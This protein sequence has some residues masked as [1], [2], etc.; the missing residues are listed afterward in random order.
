MA[1]S[2]EPQR[3]IVP[4]A[5]DALD[6][7]WRWN[8]AIPAFGHSS[9]DFERRVDHDRLRGYRLARAR[10]ALQNSPCGA[11]LLFDVN[12]IRYV[13]G[14]KIGEWERDKLCRFAL[15]AGDGD[16]IVW[17][18]GSAAVHHR[19]YCDWLKP[20]D[21]RAGMLGM[22]G[23]VPP[24]VGLMK[25]HAREIAS[26]LKEAGVADLPVGVDL[27]ETA[28][29]FELQAAGITVV[30]G[31]QIM[32]DA[33]E[34]KNFDE[35]VLLNQAA[36]M[37]DGTYHMI[38]ENLKPG[39]RENDIVAMANKLLYEMG[40]DDVE[41]INAISGERCNPHPHNFTDRYFRPGDQAFFDILQSYQGYRTCYYRTFNIGRATPA[42]HDAYTKCREWLD[43]AIALIKPGVSTDV[44]A[45]VWPKAEE[46]GFPN[47]LAAFGLQFGHGLGL[48][49]HERPIIS[50]LVSLENPME[51]KTGMVFA[52]ETYCPATDGISAA[53]IEE[54]VV[55]TDQGCQVISLF[56]AEVLPIANRY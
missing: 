21:C 42:Q 40:S 24:S 23:T 10:Q 7:Q 12:N 13:S 36:S 34:I 52:L 6:P 8:R 44:V 14:T 16:P 48:A 54:E 27:A 22:R 45:S 29:F 17:D 18:F 49:L 51:I 26:L 33:R 3:F 31:Q 46:F 35:I 9:V 55:V 32:L 41:A 53:R 25:N 15:L 11:L 28:M 2:L 43:A 1:R 30:D 20:E 47:E 50:R 5:A 37:V 38:Y 4:G 56:P 19:L 39:V